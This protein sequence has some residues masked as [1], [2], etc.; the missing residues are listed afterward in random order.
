MLL[1][2]TKARSVQLNQLKT[3][4]KGGGSEESELRYQFQVHYV[5][6]QHWFNFDPDWIKD[7]FMTRKPESFKSLYLKHILGQKSKYCFTFY[8]PIGTAKNSS[9][10]S[11]RR[12]YPVIS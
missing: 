2:A 10:I 6:S 5:R 8:V 11:V 9:S 4:K 1:S 12:P 7:K 3:Q